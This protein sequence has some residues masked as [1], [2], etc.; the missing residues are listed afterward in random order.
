MER[1]GERSSQGST[2]KIAIAA[3][4]TITPGSAEPNIEGVARSIA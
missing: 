3:P 1:T 2:N 4:M